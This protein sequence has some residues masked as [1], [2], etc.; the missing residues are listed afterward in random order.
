M[1]HVKHTRCIH[2]ANKDNPPTIEALIHK[3]THTPTSQS[4]PDVLLLES[5]RYGLNKLEDEI[6]HE[7]LDTVSQ[8]TCFT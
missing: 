2:V 7:R 1:F 6:A 4:K 8:R 5:M 3:V